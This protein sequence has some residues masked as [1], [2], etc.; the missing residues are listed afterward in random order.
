MQGEDDI[1]QLDVSVG[2]MMVV[3]EG[4]G[5]DDLREGGREGGRVGTVSGV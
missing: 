4:N 5:A 3:A 2:D 1:T